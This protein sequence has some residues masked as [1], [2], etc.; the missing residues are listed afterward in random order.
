MGKKIDSIDTVYSYK[1]MGGRIGEDCR[2]LKEIREII[3]PDRIAM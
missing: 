2:D 3:G 1:Y